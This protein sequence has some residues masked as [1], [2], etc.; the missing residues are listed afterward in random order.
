MIEPVIRPVT[1]G[2][3]TRAVGEEG[4]DFRSHYRQRSL[5]RRRLAGL[6]WL[7]IGANAVAIT[8]LWWHNGGISSVH[9]AGDVAT[10]VGRLTGLQSAY[11]AL[12]QVILVG[13]LPWLDRMVG[14]DTL[15]QWHR[16]NGKLCLYLVLAHVVFITIGYASMDMIGIPAEV[17]RLMSSYPGMVAATVG[18]VLM[19]G[20]VVT[21]LVILRRRLR[22]EAW[23]AVHLLVYAGIA[24][25]W[26]HQ[27]PTGN[28]LAVNQAAST[29]WTLLYI[30]TFGLLIV[31][32]LLHPIAAMF[33]YQL[34]VAEV[35]HEKDNVVSIRITGRH[36]DRLRVRGGQFFMWRFL[37]SSRWWSSHPFSL[38]A[39]PTAQSLR[40]TVKKVGDFTARIDE[41]RPGTRVIAEGPFGIF[42]TE[43]QQTPRVALIAGGIG[44]TPIRAMVEE[45]PGDLVLLY[46]VVH[47]GEIVF[48]E[49]FDALARK[50]GLTVH[51]VAGDH[52]GDEGRRLLSAEHLTH[53][54][55]DLLT[56]D[57]YVCG[58]PAM[59]QVVETNLR[60]AG[61]PSAHLHSER[62]AL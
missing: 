43:V 37:D 58:P 36:L 18:T 46:R 40:I 51:Y 44:I 20:V 12:L 52:R 38:S 26:V 49:E 2:E 41:L 56:R 28:E 14:F 55:P 34:R 57:I 61:V 8:W 60:G 3:V 23:Y 5:S 24:L 10:S 15:T 21:S 1:L 19:I 59:M 32:R 29:Y 45:M 13:R 53:L 47:A 31:F 22:Y 33:W 17:Q 11:L 62:F 35:T 7:L 6:V 48:A 42:S 27:I 50:R 25:A 54:V 30:I 39:L 16:L 9:S 4:A